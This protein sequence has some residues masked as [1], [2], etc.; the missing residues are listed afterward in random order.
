MKKT[1]QKR[2]NPKYTIN[3]CTINDE[4]DVY[5][6]IAFAKI[7]KDM[8]DTGKLTDVEFDAMCTEIGNN[9]IRIY[10]DENPYIIVDKDECI[11]FINKA[12]ND[13]YDTWSKLCSEVVVS[14]AD[15]VKEKKLPWYKRFWNWITRKSN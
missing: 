6:S 12:M 4:T 10:I 11:S 13:A 7:K 8:I 1:Q 5:S 14:L 9:A 3:I 15:K 2:V